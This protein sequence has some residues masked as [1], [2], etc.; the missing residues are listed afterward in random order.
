VEESEQ[1]READVAPEQLLAELVPPSGGAREEVGGAQT[2]A[3]DDCRRPLP[4]RRPWAFAGEARANDVPKRPG[5]LVQSG[6]DAVVAQASVL[7]RLDPPLF[8][9]RA[10]M[11]TD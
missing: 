9:Q 3:P 7:A 6:R 1:G 5:A 10:Q 11:P 8:G 4:V 2:A